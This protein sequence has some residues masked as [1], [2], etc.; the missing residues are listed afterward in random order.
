LFFLLLGGVT[1]RLGI[2]LIAAIAVFTVVSMIGNHLWERQ[3]FIE[4]GKRGFLIESALMNNFLGGLYFLSLLKAV[5]VPNTSFTVTTKSGA[6]VS[7]PAPMRSYPFAAA[8]FLTLEIIGLCVAWT[9]AGASQRA[10][11]YDILAFPLVIS[12]A[13]NLAAFAVFRRHERASKDT[14]LPGPWLVN[15]ET[16]LAGGDLANL[17]SQ[18]RIS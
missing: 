18:K 9:W 1:L 2:P 17:G 13:A 4:R 16:A 12:A 11:G 8:V 10:G 14:P 3:F 15:A 7:A 5:V 6:R